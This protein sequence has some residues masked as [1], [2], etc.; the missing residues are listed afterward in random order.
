MLKVKRVRERVLI[1]VS[2]GIGRL[3]PAPS[4]RWTT[5]TGVLVPLAA[6]W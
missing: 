2:Q 1:N 5:P 6:E 3:V 4:P